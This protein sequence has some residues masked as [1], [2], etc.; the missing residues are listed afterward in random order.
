MPALT[1]VDVS[2]AVRQGVNGRVNASIEHALREALLRPE[3]PWALLIF[4]LSS[5]MSG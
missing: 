1:L 5:W 3:S 2:G 4:L